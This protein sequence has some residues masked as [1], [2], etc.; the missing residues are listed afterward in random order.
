MLEVNPL[1]FAVACDPIHK[2]GRNIDL[3]WKAETRDGLLEDLELT[4]CAGSPSCKALKQRSQE[5]KNLYLSLMQQIERMRVEVYREQLESWM[6]LR[7][8]D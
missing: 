3:N 5:L 2:S 6:R 4:R 8:F 1:G 7:P